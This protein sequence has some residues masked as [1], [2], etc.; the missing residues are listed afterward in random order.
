MEYLAIQVSEVINASPTFKYVIDFEQK[1]GF[2]KQT[3][4]NKSCAMRIG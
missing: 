3:L 1:T 4:A 2:E